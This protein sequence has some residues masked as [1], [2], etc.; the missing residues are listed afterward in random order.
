[1]TRPGACPGL[2]G[3]VDLPARRW[4]TSPSPSWSCKPAAGGFHRQSKRTAAPSGSGA[5]QARRPCHWLDSPEPP[6]LARI[7][8][9]Y[10]ESRSRR[11]VKHRTVVRAFDAGPDAVSR[12]RP[13]SW[14]IHGRAGP[15]FCRTW[16]AC[17]D[18]S[19][20]SEPSF[21]LRDRVQH[22]LCRWLA[23]RWTVS[24]RASVSEVLTR[25]P[26]KRLDLMGPEEP[27]PATPGG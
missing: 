14:P 25:K 12:A 16:V 27:S 4:R 17:R 23:K 8:V 2:R 3:H 5:S 9:C 20:L 11:P 26:V 6:I 1:M 22:Q 24:P 19:T 13:M 10:L 15:L 7:L 21:Q 18:T